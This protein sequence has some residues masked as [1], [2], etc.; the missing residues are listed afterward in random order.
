M[1][2]LEKD[3]HGKSWAVEWKVE[4]GLYRGAEVNVDLPHNSVGGEQLSPDAPHVGWKEG[5]KG[6]RRRKGHIMVDDVPAGRSK[7]S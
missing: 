2:K 7:E 3:V 5:G 6:P 4:A 1:T